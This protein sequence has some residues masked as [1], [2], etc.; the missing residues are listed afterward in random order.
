MEWQLKRESRD[1][2]WGDAVT[3]WGNRVPQLCLATIQ[4]HDHH[5]HHLAV[6]ST[7][8]GSPIHIY[9]QNQAHIRYDIVTC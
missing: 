7:Q 4:S 1:A 2:A 5:P 8:P 6:L 9:K 3:Q